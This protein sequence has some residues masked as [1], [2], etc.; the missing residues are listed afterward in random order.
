PSDAQI[1]EATSGNLSRCTGYKNIVTAARAAA[2]ALAA[3]TRR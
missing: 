3:P 2:R 1:R